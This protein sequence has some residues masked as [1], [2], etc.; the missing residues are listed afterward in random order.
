MN[1]LSFPEFWAGE[2]PLDFVITQDWEAPTAFNTKP[3]HSIG[4][5]RGSLVLYN[6]AS[7]FHYMLTGEKRIPDAIARH[8]SIEN[9]TKDMAKVAQSVLSPQCA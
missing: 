4:S 6:Q 2:T 8:G 7:A 3:L 5:G 1:N 9:I